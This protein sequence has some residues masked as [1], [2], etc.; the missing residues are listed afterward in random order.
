MFGRAGLVGAVGNDFSATIYVCMPIV[1][2]FI[3]ADFISLY[4]GQLSYLNTIDSQMGVILYG[5]NYEFVVKPV[6]WF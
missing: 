6:I 2:R 4:R 1:S 3:V 5:I